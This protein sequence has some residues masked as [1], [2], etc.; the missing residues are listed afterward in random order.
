MK[1]ASLS[2]W[3]TG[4]TKLEAN[5]PNLKMHL[6]CCLPLWPSKSSAR[7]S[8]ALGPTDVPHLVE[9][10]EDGRQ[11]PGNKAALIRFQKPNQ[12]RVKRSAAPSPVSL[13]NENTGSGFQK[14]TQDD[15]EDN[16]LEIT[17]NG[18]TVDELVNNFAR[19]DLNATKAWLGKGGHIH[20]CKWRPSVLVGAK[21]LRIVSAC[22]FDMQT[23]Q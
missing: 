11:G 20:R 18:V 23:E 9:S 8:S 16:W 19:L 2:I 3:S 13:V 21:V 4:P 22:N 10:I 17:G 15:T 12:I 7:S 6:R 5:F 1:E 14:G